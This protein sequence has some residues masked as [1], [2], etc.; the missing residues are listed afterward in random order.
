MEVN[1]K[2]F[3]LIAD[4]LEKQEEKITLS[5]NDKKDLKGFFNQHYPTLSN[6]SYQIAVDHKFSNKIDSEQV[7]EIALLPP[8]AGG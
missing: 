2:Y 3:G 1:V 8:F 6:V 7:N 5:D 4:Q